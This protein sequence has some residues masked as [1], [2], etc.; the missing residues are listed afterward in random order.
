MCDEKRSIAPL[1]TETHHGLPCLKHVCVCVQ[2]GGAN[3][4]ADGAPLSLAT[5][6]CQVH[7]V[8][9][10]YKLKNVVGLAVGAGAYIL[11]LYAA[12]YPKVWLAMLG[13]R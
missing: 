9:Q 8:V 12:R 6:V 5:V 13:G 2:C 3:I 1:D 11:A 4:P 7:D 10:H